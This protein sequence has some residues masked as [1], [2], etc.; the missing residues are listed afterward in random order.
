MALNTLEGGVQVGFLEEL[1]SKVIEL[2]PDLLGD[3]SDI[4]PELPGIVSILED[5]DSI[6]VDGFQWTDI[7]KAFGLV[8]PKL[9]EIAGQKQGLTGEQ[10]KAF[11]VD[12]ATVIYFHY[13]PD[14]PLLPDTFGIEDRVEKWMVPWLA[15][16]AIE[17]AYSLWKTIKGKLSE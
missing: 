2:A 4:T 10:R 6:L 8:V 12:A 15:E 17:S 16:M 3:G 11:V 14:L 7:P 5:L 9:M 13:N 1:Q